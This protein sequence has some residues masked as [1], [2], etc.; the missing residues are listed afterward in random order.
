MREE[1]LIPCFLDVLKEL[2]P[3]K[4]FEL[5]RNNSDI[6]EW[7]G[8]PD[9]CGEEMQENL[10]Y[11]LNETLFD[12]LNEFAPPYFYFGAS[13]GDGACYGYFLSESMVQDFEG[14]KVND[15]SEVPK[16]YLG[17][18]L[19]VNDH[20]NTSLYVKSARKL[21]KIWSIV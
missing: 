16:D 8:N 21:K 15:L 6:W 19:L 3:K 9:N 1:D 17:E 14:I 13:E 20:G 2:S 4:Y 5:K 18:V 7:M 12:T 10:G 11:F